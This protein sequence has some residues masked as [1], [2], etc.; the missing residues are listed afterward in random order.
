[1]V[2]FESGWTLWLLYVALLMG[3]LVHVF[4]QILGML[5]KTKPLK[6]PLIGRI[7]ILNETSVRGIQVVA[8]VVLLVYLAMLLFA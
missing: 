2:W 6:I 7:K 3:G 1:M 8:G 4:P 5:R